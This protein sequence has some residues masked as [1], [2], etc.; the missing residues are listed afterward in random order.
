M[1]RSAIVDAAPAP[2]P[3][4]AMSVPGDG[5]PKRIVLVLPTYLPESFGGAEQQSR[6]FALALGRAGIH[7]TL[8]APRLLPATPR[9]ERDASITVRRF[10]LRKAPNL[11]GRYIGSFLVWFVKL[12]GWLWRHRSEYDVIHVVHGRLHALPAVL[13]GTALGKPTL[14]KIGRGGAE[15]FDLDVVDRKRLLGQWFARTLVRHA[16][17]YVANSRAIA[18]DLERW[19]I[20]SDGIHRIPN[21]VDLP[22]LDGGAPPSDRVRFVFLGRLDP[23]KALDFAIRGFARLPA[24][25]PASL[26]IVGEGVCR[27]DLE[28]LVEQLGVRQRVVFAG[29]VD[30]VAPVLRAHDVFVSTSVSEGM[31]NALLEAMSFG[32]LPLVSL[33]SGVADI[34]DDG[35]SGLLFSP[36]DLDGFVAKLAEALALPTEA[37]HEMGRAARATMAERF[38]IDRVAAQHVL[39]YRRLLGRRNAPGSE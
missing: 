35:R 39:L 37:R 7:V 20:P 25:A 38:G 13:A 3:G 2:L 9:V 23:E 26:T 16:T 17:A 32:L 4:G 21:G 33:V 1:D 34:V 6:K 36:G 5:A 24:D 8:L 14:I 15:H 11:G 22:D 10:R 12:Y 27:P 29:A 28:A 30:D 18:D 19:R 31:S